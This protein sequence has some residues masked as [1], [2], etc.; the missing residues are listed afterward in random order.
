ML[1]Q[2]Y[3]KEIENHYTF[4][5]KSQGRLHFHQYVGMKL[6]KLAILKICELVG[7][8]HGNMFL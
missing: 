4:S 3:K 6:V 8:F 5:S 1:V 7:F 2:K